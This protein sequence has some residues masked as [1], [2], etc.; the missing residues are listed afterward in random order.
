MYVRFCYA[1]G[2]MKWD[3]RTASHTNI[4]MINRYLA[5]I[6]LVAITDSD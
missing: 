2:R 3:L 4:N 5:T 6:I 1:L